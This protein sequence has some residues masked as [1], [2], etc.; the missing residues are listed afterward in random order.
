MEKR[1]LITNLKKTT[2]IFASFVMTLGMAPG[3]ALMANAEGGID[4]GTLPVPVA[5]ILVGGEQ[6]DSYATIQDAFEAAP[7]DEC[8]IILYDDVTVGSDDTLTLNSDIGFV[9]LDLNGKTFTVEGTITG[10][11][12]AGISIQSETPGIFNSSGTVD[13]TLG[14]YTADTY[15]ITGGIYNYFGIDGGTINISGGDFSNGIMFDNGGLADVAATISG[16]AKIKGLTYQPNS[17]YD[18]TASL[19]LTGGY[20]DVDPSSYKDN[21]TTESVTLDEDNIEEY[22]GQA[23]WEA[24]DIDPNNSENLLYKWRIKSSNS[25]DLGYLSGNT[26]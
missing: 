25:S 9:F 22:V 15:N 20:Y 5:G 24:D 21:D 18:Y 14:G 7:S 19:T 2:A 23:D 8:T 26:R 12:G 4:I 1:R 10:K 6:Y 11:S 13:V 17:E 16:N 3:T